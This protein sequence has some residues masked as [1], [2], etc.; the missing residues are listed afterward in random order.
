MTRA[1]SQASRDLE[2]RLRREIHGQVR[3]DPGSRALYATDSS[4]YRQVPIGVVLP[5]D[6]DDVMAAVA[7]C[8]EMEAPVLCRGAGTSLAGQSANTAVILDFSKYMGRI[9]E[10]DP[11]LRIAR[12][13]PGVILDQLAAQAGRCHLTF[14]PDPATHSRCTLGG[15]IGNDSCGVHSVRWGKTSAN[16]D[17]LEVLTY[18]GVKMR[19]GRTSDRELE[20]MV[21][22]PDRRGE[23]YRGLKALRDRYEELIR[24]RFPN[25]PRRVSG[26]N[27][28][29]LLPE[30]GFHVARALVGSEGTCAIV[31]EATCRL[32]ES[33]S[34]RVLLAIG[35]RD[36]F[37][38]ADLVPEILAHG[39]I[40]LEGMDRLLVEY[41]R[42]K[43]INAE[44]VAL[45]PAGA[46]WLLAEFGSEDGEAESRVR[47][48]LEAMGRAPTHPNF[49]LLLGEDAHKVWAVRESALGAVS[50]VAG[51]PQCWEGWEDAAVHPEKLGGYL[52][53][54]KKLT[55]AYHY[56]C[57]LYGH[58]GDGCVHN[59]ISF[60]LQSAEGI[61]KFRRF[62]E[63]AADLVVAFGG[64]LSGEHGD[65][66]ARA[67][68]WP[69]MFGPQLIEAFE[70]FKGLWDPAWKMNPGKLVRPNKLDQNLR[71][72]PEWD[73]S[74]SAE[75]HFRLPQDQGSFARATL[76]CVGVGSCRNQ[77]GGIMCP[78]F[79]V[80][81]D[82]E[83]STRG[84]AHL[85][86]E[87]MRGEVIQGGWRDPHVKSAL[88]LCLACKGCKAE[89][90][91]GVDVATY[92]AEFLS[93]FHHGRLRPLS[94]YAFGHIGRWARLASQLPGWANFFTQS[95][96]FS[97][98]LKLAAGVAGERRIPRLAKQSFQRWFRRREM[99]EPVP[100]AMPVV[101][102]PDTFNNY[103]HPESAI[104]AVEVLE[105]A[106]YT[107]RFP[108]AGQACCGR[109]LYDF[110]MLDEARKW[111][112]RIL[113]MLTPEI[114]QR[115]PILVLE[116]SCASVFRDELVN[117]LGDDPRAQKLA[118][119]VVLLSELLETQPNGLALPRVERKA[120]VHGHC[121]QKSVLKMGSEERLLRQMGI[122]YQIPA[123]GCCGMAGAFGFE[124]KKYPLSVAIGELELLP[125]VRQAPMDWLII[126]DGFSCREQIAQGTGR[127]ALHLAEVIRW[128]QMQHSPLEH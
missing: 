126:A 85:L 5:H 80:T 87:M 86:W 13:E 104:A 18:D 32:V 93:H 111:L 73:T 89:C 8:R 49:R 29:S 70:S 16:I 6:R 23:I 48:L 96:G 41:T 75:T 50:H 88:D 114:A 128:A 122:D 121:H 125:A 33:P 72:G 64:S 60:D 28:D 31:L 36:V 25:I 26:Y 51:E 103:F 82:E 108:A 115:V 99:R 53:E 55:D 15:M 3:F 37:E 24:Q 1:A 76:R 94:H 119:Q 120:L 56:H 84:R 12:V 40:G 52:R 123:P 81:G 105:A 90:P 74:A 27:L 59:R 79:R 69:K 20:A 47:R 45:L 95:P 110:G 112:A 35:C 21:H 11:A 39:P 91:V 57:V 127:H 19:V 71:L 113:D 9:L 118:A 66:Q 116:P 4:N 7:I 46:G 58:F 102:W 54:L 17:E 14:G 38:C 77:R 30:N 92:K 63:E 2:T 62:L 10:L 65:G 83:H 42:R 44:G 67:E 109:P 97:H 124:R 106:G 117:L 78:S 100:P 61:R 107:V 101:V 68:L 98:L 34:R 43:R 22:R